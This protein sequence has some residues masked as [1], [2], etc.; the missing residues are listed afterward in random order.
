MTDPGRNELDPRA[1][2]ILK[3]ARRARRIPPPVR[4]RVWTRLRR[5][6]W[7]DR[8]HRPSIIVGASMAAA[9]AVLLT[10]VALDPERWSSASEQVRSS[11]SFEATSPAPAEASERTEVP[12]SA[13]D[14]TSSNVSP[15]PPKAAHEDLPGPLQTPSKKRH[16]RSLSHPPAPRAT[17][18]DA[19]DPLLEET[20]LLE[21]ARQ[22]LGR[23]EPSKALTLVEQSE[24][25]FPTPILGEEREALGAMAL[26]DAE[27]PAEGR[28]AARRFFRDHPASALRASVGRACKMS[29]PR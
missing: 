19:P 23:G 24:A 13:S 22:A 26:C 6:I 18:P 2:A 12:A 7:R 14:P 25:R 4:A 8:M 16:G 15:A 27:R 10:V 11:A 17:T 1:R 20:R 5:S 3:S 29:V 21:A 28:A 9:A